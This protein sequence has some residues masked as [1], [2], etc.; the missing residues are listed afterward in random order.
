M[1]SKPYKPCGSHGC[2]ELTQ[3][4]YCSQ[5]KKQRQQ[6]QDQRRGTA[7]QRG[8]NARWRKVRLLFL[9][10]NP[11]CVRCRHEGR[12]ALA[13]VVDH[14]QPHGGNYELFWSRSNWQS[15]CTYHHNSKTASEDGG[16]NNNRRLP[17]DLKPSAIPLIIVCGPSGSG[18]TSYVNSQAMSGDIIIDLDQIKSELSG[19]PWYE[20]GDEWLTPSLIER[21]KRLA[22]LSE[23]SQGKKAWFIVSA[24]KAA[25][26]EKWSAMLKP[27]KVIVL[28][29]PP[30]FCKERLKNDSRREDKWQKY[31]AL[32]ERWWK[33]YTRRINEMVISR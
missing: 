21:N 19:M 10:A 11:W 4:R 1:P 9:R 17:S 33:E 13:S 31:A 3:E 16:F 6:Q 25:D 29:V 20:A 7:A 22:Q 26:R 14:I 2:P 8:Y 30:H 18:K 24:P 5:H 27:K 15:L 32:S 23:E 12:H 28:A